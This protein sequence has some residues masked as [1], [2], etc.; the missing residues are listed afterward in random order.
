MSN[1]KFTWRVGI[2]GA[3]LLTAANHAFMNQSWDLTLVY[4]VL[5]EIFWE[6]TNGSEND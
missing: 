2:Y 4:I 1:L 5:G 3:C 6:V